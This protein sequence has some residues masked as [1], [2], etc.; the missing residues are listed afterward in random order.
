M[1]LRLYDVKNN[2]ILVE[3]EYPAS[4]FDVDKNALKETTTYLNSSIGKGFYQEIYFDGVHIGFGDMHLP[5]KLLLGFETDF[6]TIEMHFALKGKSTAQTTK[7]DRN[8]SFDSHSHNIIYTNGL[9]GKMQWES[10][11][12]QICEINLSKSFFKRFLPHES[13]LFDKF[14]NAIEKG[15]SSL[16]HQQHHQINH[17]MYQILEQ[18]IQ[19]KKKEL[20]KRM[21]LEAKVIELLLLQLEQFHTASPYKGTLKRKDIDK[22]YVVRDFIVNNLNS[23][24][25]L[26]DLAHQAGTNEFILKKGFKEIFGTT[27]FSFWANEKMEYAKALLTE[28]HLTISEIAYLI[29]YKNQRHFSSAFK[30][31][32]GISPSQLYK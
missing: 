2:Q 10:D 6:E 8:I 22:I 24:Y 27:V 1:A 3:K 29:G 4:F 30:K 25:S 11:H 20:F 15:I 32:F 21:F 13:Q 23:S 14:K 5:H 28:Q 16:L 17:Q 7:F 9:C 12:F 18:I 31:K 26:I 19:C